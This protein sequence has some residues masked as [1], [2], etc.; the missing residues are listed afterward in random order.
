MRGSTRRRAMAGGGRS[1]AT[2]VSRAFGL[3]AFRST[4]VTVR[5]ER[6]EWESATT[7]VQWCPLEYPD[8]P[9]VNN[10]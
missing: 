10:G 5:D 1:T 8:P 9:T 3:S 7:G 2:S 6:S 4:I